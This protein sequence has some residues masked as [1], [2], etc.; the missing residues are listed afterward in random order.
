MILQAL[1]ELAEVEKL[2][3]DPDYEWKPVSFLVQLDATGKFL[4]F[5]D[6][7]DTPPKEGNKKPK[8]VPKKFLV[9][10]QP[11]RSGTKAPPSFLVDNAKY[12]FGL[13]TS[14][15]QFPEDEGREKSG[16]FLEMIRACLESTNDEAICA[17]YN[18]L[19]KFHN[20]ETQV[21]L[22]KDCKSNMQFGFVVMPDVDILVSERSKIKNY[23][24]SQREEI[25]TGE[26][27]I[28]LVLG[29]QGQPA[30]LFPQIMKV[31]GG[32]TS[33]VGLVSYN[34]N[35]FE[36][37][38]WKNNQNAP[39]SRIAAEACATALNRLLDPASPDPVNLGQ[40]LPKRH[41]R[42]SSD[43]V[44][45]Y[46]APNTTHSDLIDVFSGL[47][48]ANPEVV[49]E[50][51]KSVW[52]GEL[53][54]IKDPSTFYALTLTGTQGRAIVRDW[55]QTSV[56]EMLDNLAR[57]FNDIA[58]V[59]NTPKPKNNDLPPRL[60]LNHLLS[61]LAVQGKSENIPGPLTAK[62]LHAVL[63]GAP[64]PFAV[65]QKAVERMRAEIGKDDWMGQVRRDA[66]A[67]LIKAV[68]NRRGNLMEV[69]YAMDPNNQN[70][71]YLMGRLMAVLERMQQAAL[72]D[73]NA[74]VIDRFFSG[75][76]ASPAATFPRLLKNMRHHARKA[77]DDNSKRGWV[78]T[79]EKEA[80]A[81]LAPLASFPGYLNIEQQGLFI[82]G[83]HHQRHE[84]WQSRKSKDEATEVESE[85]GNE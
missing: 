54:S 80:D 1:Y 52:A 21:E 20:G 59:R 45:T 42:L 74:T 75:A 56:G 82:L 22:P 23:W 32:T 28:C 60:P 83:Y 30:K 10:R 58:I 8:P 43:T 31:P 29:S 81:I 44:V 46:W 66:R 47:L 33:G 64:F 35:A 2:V 84:L 73:V 38:G 55:L 85:S 67:A 7:H 25:E 16:W 61:S 72:G 24:K 11:G 17:V 34:K 12:V 26:S 6:T 76:S 68:L 3:D 40:T 49:G 62:F 48:E 36:S 65:L 37:Y 9:P 5:I 78:V 69:T 18:F 79:L 63:S 27:S 19:T 71:G 4:G 70:P 53:H 15:K 51:Y 50:M 39:V 77:K 13:S 41:L 14:D 57:Y